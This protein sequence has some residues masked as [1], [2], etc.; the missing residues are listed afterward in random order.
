[1]SKEP[2]P[3]HRKVTAPSLRLRKE[4]GERFAIVTA[5]DFPSARA[6]E[7]AG[8]DV[9]LVGDSLGMVEL[10][11]QN[12]LPV[13]MDEMV[14]HCRAVARGAR[15]PLLVGDMPFL[16]YQVSP[17][18][19]VR[20][21]GRFVKE[22][23]MDAVKLEGAG[24]MLGAVRAILDAGVPVMGHVGLTP[25]SI[26]RLGGFRVQGKDRESARRVLEDALALEEAGCFAVVLEA[27]PARL[28]ALVTSR[29]R[30]PS[31]GIGAGAGC[32]AQV[33]VAHDLLGL[34]PGVTARFV[35]RYESLFERTVEAFSAYRSDVESGA[36][37]A[38]EHRYE[39][40]DEE[41]RALEAELAG[42]ESLR[43]ERRA[44]E[45]DREE[46]GQRCAR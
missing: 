30:I 22:G 36:F 44:P 39:M 24:A 26:H 6:A 3:V 5:C 27:V 19:A 45:A 12:T 7:D 10:G 2:I 9:L 40:P 31:V 13:T 21:A 42:E 29:L 38:A 32:D 17:E 41:W 25:Q 18:E 23:G 46:G 15:R 16:S 14:H 35:K 8:I 4:A 28:A 33:L 20:N 34:L 37:P 43:G 1:M 11:Y